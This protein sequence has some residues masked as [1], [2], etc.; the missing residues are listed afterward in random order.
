MDRRARAHPGPAADSRGR[1]SGRGARVLALQR[2]RHLAKAEAARAAAA[3]LAVGGRRRRHR[4][5][6]AHARGAALHARLGRH[7]KRDRSSNACQ[8]ANTV[9]PHA[10]LGAPGAALAL[11]S[12]PVPHM[13]HNQALPA[14]A[15]QC[16]NAL[17]PTVDVPSNRLQPGSRLLLCT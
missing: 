13:H 2:R 10:R 9:V 3:L 1:V 6:A 5:R 15:S 11:P 4:L 7:L 8:A 12:S 14:S 16:S 17:S